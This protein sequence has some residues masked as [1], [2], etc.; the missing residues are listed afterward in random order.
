MASAAGRKARGMVVSNAGNL[1][2][3]VGGI[4]TF[5]K[6]AFSL[7]FGLALAEAFKQFVRDKPQSTESVIDWH[8]L[9]SLL[10]FIFLIFPFYQ[11]TIR[12]FDVEFGDPAKLPQPFSFAIM[13]DSFA[14]I[15][16]AALF[17]VMSRALAP[18]RWITFYGAIVALLW[19]DSVWGLIAAKLH[20]GGI[21]SWIYLNLIFGAIVA[22][23]LALQ[24]RLKGYWPV[25][26]GAAAILIRT[27]LDYYFNWSFYFP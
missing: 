27:I 15:C 26:L 8:R 2:A 17:F 13:I 21:E 10:A 18:E 1:A 5:F 22:V 6:G 19:V 3:H 7:L 9:L 24:A 14:F 11:G 23:M 12:F 20:A 25:G 4:I 16:E